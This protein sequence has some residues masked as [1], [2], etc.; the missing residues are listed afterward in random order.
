MVT[1]LQ[2][3]PPVLANWLGADEQSR[4]VLLLELEVD[5]LDNKS[6]RLDLN[7]VFN[8][9]RLRRGNLPRADWYIGST[10]AEIYFDAVDG[11]VTENYTK[12]RPLEVN[13]KPTE[14]WKRKAALTL[15]PE[16]DTKDTSASTKARLGDIALEANTE[17]V[18]ESSFSCEERLLSQIHMTNSVKWVIDLP[19]GSKV[20]RD[21]LLGNLYLCAE[22]FWLNRPR[23]GRISV[24]PADVRFF[25][26]ERRA[27]SIGFRASLGMRFVLYRRKIKIDNLD[28]L[29]INFTDWA[30]A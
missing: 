29:T 18:F 28:G 14:T 19:K 1:S 23:S 7:I 25:D 6:L 4:N 27:R 13:Y 12:G 10:G 8:P 9:I 21:F 2:I 26:E 24:R 15:R 3:S 5:E 17:R 30:G 20:V 11:S 16:I 22:C